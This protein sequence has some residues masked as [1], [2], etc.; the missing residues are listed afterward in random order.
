MRVGGWRR[1]VVDMPPVTRRLARGL[2]RLAMT[3]PSFVAGLSQVR[4]DRLVEKSESTNGL[5]RDK[6]IY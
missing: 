4:P 5:S 3:T 1:T 6:S 2:S